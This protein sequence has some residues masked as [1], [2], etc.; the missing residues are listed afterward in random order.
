[1][2]LVLTASKDTYITNKI[3]NNDS[4]SENSN[5]GFAASLDL[6]KLYEESGFFQDGD[7]ITEGVVEKSAILVKFDYDKIGELTSSVLDMRSAKFKAFL[8]LHDVSSGIQK[9]YKFSALCNPLKSDF[10]EG[11]GIDVSGFND[12]GSANYLTSSFYD[13]SPVKWNTA[14]ASSAGGIGSV[15]AT[16]SITVAN[17]VGLDNTATFALNDGTNTV[18]FTAN[19]ASNSHSRSSATNYIVGINGAGDSATVADRIFAA[20]AAAKTGVGGTPDLNITATDPGAGAVVELAQDSDGPTGNTTIVLGG[21]ASARLTIV[22]F[23]NGYNENHLDCI[24][25]GSFGST[26]VD[27]GADYYFNDPNDNMILD[28]TNAV[29]SSVKGLISNHGFRI[30]FSGS[31]DTDQ[32]T[33]FVKRFGSRHIKNKM[34]VPRLR[35]LFDDSI[36]DAS[37]D[38]FVDIQGSL[39]FRSRSGGTISNLK[40]NSGAALQ[41]DNCGQVYIS[42]GSYNQTVNFSQVNQSSQDTRR[43]GTYV[44]SFTI[45]SN[46]TYVKKALL[47]NPAGFSVDVEWRSNDSP[48]KVLSKSSMFVKNYSSSSLKREDI[49][50]SF[51]NRKYSY[52]LEEDIDISLSIKM[53]REDYAAS[54]IRKE[55]DNLFSPT[56]FKVTEML[57]QK[58]VINYDF[59]YN[60][61]LMSFYD[62]KYYVRIPAGSLLPGFTYILEACSLV[63]N[64]W[65][66]SGKKDKFFHKETF[67]FKVTE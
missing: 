59:A 58:E 17:I 37:Q 65:L 25:S 55:P 19:T 35:I 8:E 45:P 56:Y 49:A 63:N 39:Y 26:K 64:E 9:P 20:I 10:E 52:S 31:Y 40:N 46:N 36:I 16:G 42:S 41:G 50:L 60:S 13:A 21:T 12:I 7:Y 34:L 5:A 47:A 11:H 18:T 6:F 4:K 48:P 29:S 32:K 33:R 61:T 24:T 44:A 3:I 66:G 54:K 14:G 2:Q 28:V 62:G 1:M 51:L 27:F 15:K 22:N 57:S 53:N 67:K 30:G 38:S 43:D 23:R